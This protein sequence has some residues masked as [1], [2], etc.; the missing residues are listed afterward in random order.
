MI[1][2]REMNRCFVRGGVV[3]FSN[4]SQ[5]LAMIS[6]GQKSIIL[7]NCLW[8][9]NCAWLNGRV[10]ISFMASSRIWLLENSIWY[11]ILVF[12]TFEKQKF[13]K[14]ETVTFSD[15][16]LTL[17]QRRIWAFMSDFFPGFLSFLNLKLWK[18]E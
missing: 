16:S 17:V 11:D 15:V 8:W 13:F 12:D 18:F 5:F 9:K 7:Y 14:L 1:F 4:L 3:D 2:A 6:V 10:R